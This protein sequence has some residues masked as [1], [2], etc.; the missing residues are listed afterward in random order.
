[1]PVAAPRSKLPATPCSPGREE[2]PG[3]KSAGMGLAWGGVRKGRDAAP[4]PYGEARGALFF[5]FS[6]QAGWAVP[7]DAGLEWTAVLPL[8]RLSPGLR[9]GDRASEH[10]SGNKRRRAEIGAGRMRSNLWHF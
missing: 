9:P 10:R 5:S 6:V 7:F 1:M 8:T 2:R 3:R 4:D